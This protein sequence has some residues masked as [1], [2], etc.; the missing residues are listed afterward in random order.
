MTTPL[1]T[2]IQRFGTRSHWFNEKAILQSHTLVNQVLEEM[3]VD[4]YYYSIGRILGSFRRR[5][6]YDAS[7]IRVHFD[8]ISPTA[9]WRTLPGDG[10]G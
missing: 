4:V 5:E 1:I 8:K 7:P 9:L 6:I 2:D 3:D 10:Q